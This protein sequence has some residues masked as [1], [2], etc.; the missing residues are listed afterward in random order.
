[1][2][3]DVDVIVGTDVLKHFKFCLDRGKFSIAAAAAPSSTA[4]Q[5]PTISK[6]NFQV[7][8]DGEKWVTMWNWKKKPILHNCTDVYAMDEVIQQRFE[9]EVERWIDNRW[10]VKSNSPGKGVITIDGCFARKERQSTPC[11]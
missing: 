1:M 3:P 8:F 5:Y 11:A 9:S 10:L 7:R 2:V 4:L 6:S